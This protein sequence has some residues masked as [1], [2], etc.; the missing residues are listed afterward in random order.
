MLCNKTRFFELWIKSTQNYEK[1]YNFQ[2]R[3]IME[4]NL[5]KTLTFGFEQTF[6]IPEWWTEPGFTSTSDTPL[7]REKML[8]LARELAAELG[9]KYFES[10]DIWEHMQY[11]VTDDQGETQFYVTM[12]PGSIE[13]K[14]PPVLVDKTFEMAKPLFIAAERAGVVAYRNWWY[15]VQA[16]TEGGCHVNMGGFTEDTNP[17]KKDPTLV[18]KYAAYVHNR[19]W[20]HHPFMG[21]DVGPEGNAM[22]MDEKP[23][24]ED[25]KEAF[26]D[27]RKFLSDGRL[28]TPQET[29]DHFKDT[30]LI[31]EKGSYPSLYKFKTGLFLIE[32]R[33]QESLRTAEDFY[34]V[35]EMRMQIFEY[36]QKQELPESLLDFPKLHEEE[37]TSFRLWENFKT[38][39]KDFDLP[40]EKYHRF[41]ERQFPLL[42]Q[43]EAPAKLIN[44][45][46]GR[47]P[48][49][50]TDIQKR[51]D[52]VI[53][54]TIDTTY[55]RFEIFHS[56]PVGQDIGFDIEANGVETISPVMAIHEKGQEVS[57]IYIDLKYDHDKPQIHIK[58]KVNGE[59]KEEAIFNAKD[60]MWNP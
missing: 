56:H 28:F 55:K 2:K 49:V 41:F 52:V 42:E 6:T 45:K 46:D 13:L 26:E 12:D 47:R 59:F 14:T 25:V 7:K 22:R 18:V 5:R 60:M 30:N 10:K 43:G 58:L 21:I 37:L 1:C 54:K 40:T 50:I 48:R 8:D 51:G 31:A 24:Y 4:N 19:P 20:L 44:I 53:S 33:G 35:S 16:G 34:L 17:L 39:A 11:E 57:F 29:Y 15:G 3:I 27:Y 9:G 38:W 36:L 32:D 23:G